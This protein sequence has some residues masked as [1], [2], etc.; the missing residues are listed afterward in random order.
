MRDGVL[1][2]G[3]LEVVR[4]DQIAEVNTEP[5]APDGDPLEVPDLHVGGHLE[6]DLLTVVP[7]QFGGAVVS[8]CEDY[9]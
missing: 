6:S 1:G 7:A 8:V 5:P 3:E 9:S 4:E 2:L